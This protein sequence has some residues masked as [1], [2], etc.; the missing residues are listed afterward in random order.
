[1]SS[2]LQGK[3]AVITGGGRGLGRGVALEMARAQAQVVVADLYRDEAGQSAAGAVVAEI[4]ELGGKAVACYE[5]VAIAEQATAIINTAIDTF[6]RIDVLCTFAGNAIMKRIL[7]VTNEDF[8]S[9]LKVHLYGTYNCLSAALPHMLEQGSGRIVT[10]SSR[11]AFQGPVPAY[12]AA[13]AGIMGLTAAVAME[14]QMNNTGVTVN[15]LMPSAQTQLFPSV[16]PRPLGGMPTPLSSDPDDVAPLVAYLATD[17]ASTINGRF[18]YASG[19]DVCVYA[20][21]FQVAGS[22][23]IIRKPGRWSIGELGALIAPIAGS[24]AG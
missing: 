24:G 23:A 12:S 4:G 20:S 13:K 10:V 8:D 17:A 11:G 15:C 7:D 6:G 3:V 18:I 5:D 9:S 22:N 2:E 19:G 21:P 1:M 14:M 16:G